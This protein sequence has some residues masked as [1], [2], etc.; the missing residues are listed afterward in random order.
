MA[1]SPDG[2]HIASGSDDK[3]IRIWDAATGKVVA[4]PFEGHARRVNSLA[5]L[6]DGT[7]VISGSL[8]STIRSWEIHPNLN[9]VSPPDSFTC[10]I[11]MC[12]FIDQYLILFL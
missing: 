1:F 10:F 7:S 12:H 2:T 5:F 8:D 9:L 6:P 3:T 11:Y 4:G